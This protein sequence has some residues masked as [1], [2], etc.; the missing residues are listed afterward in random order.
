MTSETSN[1][2]LNV[3]MDLLIFGLICSE[4]VVKKCEFPKGLKICGW[5]PFL[6][7]KSHH[8]YTIAPIDT[9]F[10]MHTKYP[11]TSQ[12][13]QIL[14][15]RYWGHWRSNLF[16]TLAPNSHIFNTIYDLLRILLDPI[17]PSMKHKRL[18]KKIRANF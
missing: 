16:F 6:F 8:A 7:W 3:N 13:E 1:K 12:V 9:I 14:P 5:A 10:C 4:K 18:L 17:G 11:F 2:V 15:Q